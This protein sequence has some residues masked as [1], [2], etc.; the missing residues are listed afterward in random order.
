VKLL[1]GLGWIEKAIEID[2][3]GKEDA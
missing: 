1:G 2:Q 3:D